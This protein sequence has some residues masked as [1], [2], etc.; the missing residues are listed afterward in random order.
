MEDRGRADSLQKLLNS[1]CESFDDLESELGSFPFQRI[2]LELAVLGLIEF[3]PLVDV[4]HPVTQHAIYES[5]QLGGH[6]F[7]GDRSPEFR[8]QS[9]E[10][11]SQI[12]LAL[13]QAAGRHLES[14]RCPVVGREPTLA[15]DFLT[16]NSIVGTKP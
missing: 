4:V 13:S 5:G 11:C 10:L 9:A 12:S 15:N 14:D 8:S 6:G 2:N 16:T 1:S 7:D 3:H